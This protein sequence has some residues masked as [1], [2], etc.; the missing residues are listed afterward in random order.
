MKKLS[1]KKGGFLRKIILIIAIIVFLVS[2]GTILF[3]IY[4]Y[5]HSR[6][7]FND[8][9]DKADSAISQVV[10]DGNKGEKDKD[11]KQKKKA[12]DEKNK[13]EN[14]TPKDE[15]KVKQETL[16]GWNN[17]Y[18]G[19]IRIDGTNVDYPVM[20]TPNDPEFYLRRDFNRNYSISGTPFLDGYHKEGSVNHLVYAHNMNDGSMFAS[21]LKYRDQD[22]FDSHRY[23]R[24]DKVDEVGVYEIISFFEVDV[25]DPSTFKFYNYSNIFDEDTFNRY[26][27]AAKAH[28]AYDTGSIA[29][30]GDKLLTLSTCAD[31]DAVYRTVVIAKKVL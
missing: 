26:I 15:N 20:Y 25:T 22:F 28:S 30:W 13:K 11:K 17:D 29:T 21:L 16:D 5:K 2:S 24:F 9:R 14:I 1:K 12:E 3:K 6:D 10:K 31:A 23:I 7:Q 8:L 27:K 19:W 18:Y 4:Q